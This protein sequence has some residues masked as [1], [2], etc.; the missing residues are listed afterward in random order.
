M[1]TLTTPES[2]Q[3]SDSDGHVSRRL[4]TGA[5]TGIAAV[6]GAAVLVAGPSVPAMFAGM[7]LGNHNETVLAPPPRPVVR[8]RRRT[9]AA[10]SICLGLATI[11]LGAG[12]LGSEDGPVELAVPGNYGSS[13][14]GGN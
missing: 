10:V 3:P 9:V 13:T 1:T 5:I 11:G 2:T 6:A 7:N 12:P 8:R 4:P 14:G